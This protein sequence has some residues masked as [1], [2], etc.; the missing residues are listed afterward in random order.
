MILW[1]ILFF[2]SLL[3]HLF[4]IGAYLASHAERV[5]LGDAVLSIFLALYSATALWLFL[6]TL[7]EMFS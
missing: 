1:T 6:T 5:G 2:I 3:T 7:Q 4:M